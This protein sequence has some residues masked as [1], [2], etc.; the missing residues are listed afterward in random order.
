MSTVLARIVDVWHPAP[1][2][3]REGPGEAPRKGSIKR[4]WPS[5]AGGAYNAKITAI[6]HEAISLVSVKTV[7]L[8][9]VF[10]KFADTRF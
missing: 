7:K 1:G 4:F 8:P 2:G 9:A 3:A 6:P 10:D 5:A